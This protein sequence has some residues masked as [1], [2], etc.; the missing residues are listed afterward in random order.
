MTK[1]GR[2]VLKGFAFVAVALGGFYW[3]QPQRYDFFPRPAPDPNPPVDPDTTLLFKPGTRVSVVAAHPDDPE[4]FIGGTLTELS[5]AGCKIEIVMCTDGDKGYYPWFMT[6]AKE[7]RVV[8]TAEQRDAASQYHAEVVFLHEPDGRLRANNEVIAKVA[9]A[10]LDFQPDY[11]LTFDPE[12]PPKVQH[13]DHLQSGLAAEEAVKSVSSVK[14]LMQFSTHAPNHFV[15]ISDVWTAKKSL[16]AIHKSQFHG[17]RLQMVVNLVG[18]RAQDE[19][20]QI[21]VAY[22]EG[23]RCTRLR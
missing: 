12:Y 7:N 18:S 21:G 5:R 14:W 20:K 4:F 15:D 22:A 16:L 3:Y 11:V 13:S 9:Q 19:G 1:R 6:D 23:F 10:L 8:R 17:D 2:R